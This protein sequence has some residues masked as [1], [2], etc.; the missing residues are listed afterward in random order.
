MILS[1][2]ATSLQPLVSPQSNLSPEGCTRTSVAVKCGAFALIGHH[3]PDAARR[4]APVRTR[5]CIHPRPHA[6]SSRC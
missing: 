4:S 3:V 6:E 2:E 1:R 5:G